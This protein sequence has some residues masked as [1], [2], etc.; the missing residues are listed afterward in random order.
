MCSN[1]SATGIGE[2]LVDFDICLSVKYG[3][4]L[5]GSMVYIQSFVAVNVFQLHVRLQ[6]GFDFDMEVWL[7]ESRHGLWRVSFFDQDV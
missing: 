7:V 3:A 2:Q 1:F 6:N 5:V 4:M